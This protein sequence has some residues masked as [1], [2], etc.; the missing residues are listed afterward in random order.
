[1]ETLEELK[2]RIDST[3][4]MQSI[5]RT[6]K[7]MAAVRIRQFEKA[8]ES[9]EAYYETVEMALR[10]VLMDRSRFTIGAKRGP[11]PKDPL[12]AV[13]F[14]SDQGMCG[15]LNDQ[16][17]A[18]AMKEMA[19]ISQAD[20]GGRIVM[21]VGERMRG[22]LEDA[23]Q[24]VDASIPVPGSVTGITPSVR[25]ILARIEEWHEKS[26]I[27]RIYLFYSEHL[28]GASYK[29]QTLH[30]LPVDREWLSNIQKK[31]WPGRS[32]PL[33]TMDW[34]PLFSALIRQYLFV[35]LFR[36]FA[37]SLA[38]ENASRLASMQGAEK[39]IEERLSDLNR[40][41]HQQRQMSITEELIDIV[42]GFEALE[43][44]EL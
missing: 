11:G 17:A 9:L 39:N 15:Q 23:G 25:H 43:E 8:A 3:N 37:E 24:P 40:K 5:V 18:H 21:A 16:M 32:L 44:S 41:Y 4:D 29:S 30:L 35:S 6:M 1:M 28:S 27:G 34:D 14:G 42:S 13:V 26:G 2:G 12:G 33:F 20:T 36:A 38:S 22:R 19:G 7:A 10:V 31:G